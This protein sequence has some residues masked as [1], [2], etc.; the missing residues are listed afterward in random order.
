MEILNR[1]DAPFGAGVWQELDAT[2]GEFLG[3]R[4]N[5]R[6]VVDF[7]ES[8]TYDDDAI[9]TKEVKNVTSKKGLSIAT[10][11]PIKMVE[12][13]QVFSLPKSVVEDIKRGVQDYDDSALAEAA[14]TFA[15]V[16]NQMILNGLKEANIEGIINK[17]VATI[18]IKSAKEILSGVAKSLGVFNKNFVEGG[19]K[20]V[21]SSATMAQLHTEFFDGI[22]VKAKIDDIIGSGNIVVN[23]DIGD[24]QALLVSLRGE[25]FE[26]YSG[27]D[28]SLG[29]E[30]DSKDA[31][32]LF[33]MQTCAFRV[34]GPEAAVLLQIK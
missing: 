25:D 19:F 20:L 30:N 4:L 18:E 17:E 6:S 5:M 24:K 9:A 2:L 33:L 16:E 21:V 23:E 26:F 13:K 8:Y 14:N 29:Y 10:R 32:A 34:L 12:I 22:S 3:K 31:V 1:N 7:D 15:Q 28:V 27:L 11:E